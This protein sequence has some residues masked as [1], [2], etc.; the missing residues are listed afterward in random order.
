MNK[1][2]DYL[3][4]IKNYILIVTGL[5]IISLIL[6]F[7][8]SA[9]NPE[10][11]GDFIEA[12][13]DLAER[14]KAIEPPLLQLIVLFLII[15]L[16]NALKSLAVII[17]GA[18]FGIIPLFF[19][20]INGQAIGTVVYIFTEEKGVP[21][22]LA[23]LLP[24][25]IIEIPVI[26]ISAGIGVK[27]GYRAYLSLKEGGADFEQG[28]PFAIWFYLKKIKMDLTP[29]LKQGTGFYLRWL[30]PMLFLAAMVE[31]SVTPLIINL[32]FT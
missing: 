16:N 26:L 8:E 22:V 9:A 29:E 17:L 15:F 23:A 11:S 10:T 14:I 31:S 24:H 12:F 19:V 30:L 27:I 28:L 32:L 4:S 3:F 5:F 25:G 1:D 7:L 6:G 18:G 2:I 20:A 13:K 21:Y